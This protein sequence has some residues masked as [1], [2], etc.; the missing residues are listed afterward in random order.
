VRAAP[1]QDLAEVLADEQLNALALMQAIPH[2]QIAELRVVS[3]PLTVGSE[4]VRLASPPPLLGEH[5]H[6]V[7]REIGYAEAKL[8]ELA[9]ARAIT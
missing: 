6:E 4:R 1:V 3:P 8:D 7:L 5:T 9:A 2:P